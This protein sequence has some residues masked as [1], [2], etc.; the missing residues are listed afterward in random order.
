MFVSWPTLQRAATFYL[1]SEIIGRPRQLLSC[2]PEGAVAHNWDL[3]ELGIKP[4]G[5]ENILFNV[6]LFLDHIMEVSVFIIFLLLR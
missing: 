2:T 1:S 5:G 4:E 3:M 6:V